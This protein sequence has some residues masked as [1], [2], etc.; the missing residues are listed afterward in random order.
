MVV[1]V[2]KAQILVVDDEEFIAKL[3][4]TVIQQSGHITEHI[5]NACEAIEVYE[6]KKHDM[7]LLDLNMPCM[8][9]MDLI[10][11]F[12]SKG[13]PKIIVVSGVVDK[14]IE[15]KCKDAG[16]DDF[17]RKPFRSKDLLEKISSHLD[18]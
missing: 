11:A 1:N 14:G 2:R 4:E 10:R 17:I 9:G 7:V 6:K 3:L 13:D 5:C 15:Q 12:R 8:N 18:L 16:A